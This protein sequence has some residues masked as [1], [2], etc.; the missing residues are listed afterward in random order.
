MTEHKSDCSWK[1]G[2]HKSLWHRCGEW[3][4]DLVIDESGVFYGVKFLTGLHPL[5]TKRHS[6]ESFSFNFC[7]IC[8]VKLEKEK[9]DD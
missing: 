6:S 7:P 8:G 3:E 1:N 9:E 5:D 2:W 4:Y